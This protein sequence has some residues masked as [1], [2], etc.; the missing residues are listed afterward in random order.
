MKCLAWQQFEEV[1]DEAFT[2]AERERAQRGTS[3]GFIAKDLVTEMLHVSPYLMGSP[4]RMETLL[5][6]AAAIASL[7]FS[8]KV[9]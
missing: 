4:V 5:V 9:M 8:A 7:C 1:F 6:S 2:F 3:I